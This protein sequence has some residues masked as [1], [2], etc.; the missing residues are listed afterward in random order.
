MMKTTLHG[1]LI[2]AIC[3]SCLTPAASFAAPGTHP[4]LDVAAIDRGRILS[5][6]TAA[7][8]LPPITITAFRAQLSEGGPN[9]FY[10]N[11]D[12]WWPDPTKTD[13]LP[14]IQ[15]DG[16]SNP[17]N[18]SQHRR[19]IAQLRDSV[20]A[21]AA[22]YK[23]TGEDRYA[24]KAAE[25]LRVFFLDPKMRMNPHLK[26]AQAIPGRTPGRGIGII[27]TL[28]LVEVPLAVEALEKSPAFP[29]ATLAGLKAWFHDYAEWMTTNK[30]GQEE[31]AAGN[32]HAVA[33][34]LQI[35]AFAGFAGDEVKL[36]EC[37]RRF[38]E[39]FVAKQMAP[40]GSFP[41][42]LK[43]TKPY[44]YSIFQLD[45][46]A[47]LCQMLSTDKD[48]LWA[49]SLPDGRGIR[50]AMEFLYPYLAD[51]SKWPRK[52]DVQA[53]DGWP[54]R[55]P[56]L[57]FA[58]LAFG[59]HAYLDL[60]QRLPADPADAEVRRNIAITQPLLW[61]NPPKSSDAD[62]VSEEHALIGITSTKSS[63]HTQHPDA[64]WFPEAGFGLFIHWGL[65]SV[66][67]MNISWP[68]I[69]G[70]ALAKERITE[71]AERERIIREADWNLRGK[72]PDLTPNQYWE[73]A[74]E[75]NPQK[76][77]PDQWLKAA[78]AAGFTY[79]VLTT[80]HHEGFSLWP[81]A[82]DD[83]N[84]KNYMG[85]RDL[86]KDYV[87]AC[88]R[89]GIKVGF[90]YSPPDWHFDRDY[91]N[92]LYHGAVKLN[93]EFP[94]LDADLKPRTTKPSPE[95]L[96]KHQEA[97]A[98]LVN[99]QVEELLTRYGKIDL[100]WFDGK[101]AAGKNKV[102]SPE[103]IRELQPGIVINPRLHGHGDFVTFERTLSAKQPVQGWAEFCN[104][105]TTCWSHMDIPF[106]APGYVLGQLATS[107][108]LG[109]NYLL[110]VG[111]MSTGEFCDGIYKNMAIVGDWMKR[112]S[113]AVKAVQPLPA[114]ESA[115][116]PA[117][118]AGSTRYLFAL[119]RFKD[120]GAY[121]T[122][123]LPAED[124]TLT[125]AGAPKPVRVT[126][127]ADGSAL[128]H[129]CSGQALTIR[130]PAAKRSSLVD[131]VQV[132][133]VSANGAATKS[134]QADVAAPEIRT[135]KAPPTP[136]I[137]GPA[138]CGVR[139]GRPFFYHIPA[140]G[141]RP[142]EFSADHLPSGL[143]LD[144][145]TGLIT[146]S[147]SKAGEHTVTL[148]A[149]NAKGAA[150]RPFKIVVGETI[151]LTPPLGWN[152]WN[153]WGSKV[154][155]EKV[156]QSARGMVASGLINHGWTYMNIDDAW[157]GK[158]GGPFHAI[159]GNEKFPDMKGLCDT[160]H[161]M[162]L[163]VGIYSTPWVTSYA[164]HIG[165]SAENPEGAWSPPTIPKK[166]NVN[167]K[168]LP[169]A[170]G[171][172]HFATNDAKQWAAWG[173]DYLKYDWNP[174]EPPET[175][176]MYDALRA[177]GRDVVFSLSNNSPFTNAPVLSKIAN[178]WRTTGDIR[179]NWDSMNKK[180][181]GQDK[182]EPYAAPGHWNDPDMLV[183]GRVG[184]G[185]PHPTS[186]TPDEQYTHITLWCL[187]AS[188][189]LLGCDLDK[190]DDFTL[191][192]LS[193]DEVLAIN[194]DA[195]GRQA[196]C[197][198]R[199]GDQRVYAKGLA[200]GSKAVG[201]FNVGTE[202]AQVTAKWSDLTLSGKLSVRDLW[203]QKD[204]GGFA[205]EFSLPVAPHGAEMVKIGP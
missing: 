174:N 187:L 36:A 73:L 140:T 85:G 142:M 15:R 16:E 171:Q 88:R 6:A 109:V 116:V 18:F 162:G 91:M 5:A 23:I 38:K 7:L 33:F 39:V 124:V 48:N 81:S 202:R 49:F 12:Y 30:N 178:C 119:P 90:Y 3:F 59:E 165:G 32:N 155:A 83:F 80:R 54:A 24:A 107:R 19:C 58:G 66:K 57:L 61:L 17:N 134:A 188:P 2:A 13:G 143:Q 55:Q 156:L 1:P 43:R 111:P 77:D 103:R 86:L 177:S 164:N 9:D 181:F 123:L 98:V 95:D 199:D 133:L 67:A 136:R 106:R 82:Y 131:V 45:N 185:N 147:I 22:A 25:L 135:P 189:L 71:P 44:G 204:L 144:V 41:A 79:A 200:D 60:W 194:Q 99:G 183:V 122:D 8:A 201:L 52:P 150:E 94:S 14:Y 139:P 72:K 105:W 63:T 148:R 21:L 11:G 179:D 159:Q 10:S 205:G 112:N 132:D 180:G 27:D 29:S 70:R 104:T 31:A 37:R 169:W 192:L 68:M 89:H 154:D 128:E 157:Q 46:M 115:S 149:R 4:V 138:V 75:F 203:R 108:S 176:E 172:Y 84:T 92:F 145:R 125:L 184:W 51:K 166:G 127:T 100:L 167:K 97:Y 195:L 193:N 121:E 118:A 186:L 152:S 120:S 102:I 137:N 196:L 146:G 76:Y 101:P 74:R 117:T 151:A 20:A 69:P 42:E 40:D 198:A 114:A 110:G 126:L 53:W 47:A 62:T 50:K 26:Y 93:P 153:C 34:F 87:E 170:I 173:I 158:R 175:Q 65:S 141:D 190:L 78:K 191:N 113:A 161:Q 163:K 182:W 64:Q 168:I 96:A 129:D 130:L 28:H 197:V 56:S 35:A 160:I